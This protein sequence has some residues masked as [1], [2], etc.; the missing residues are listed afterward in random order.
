MDSDCL[1]SASDRKITFGVCFRLGSVVIS[2]A[3]GK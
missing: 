3:S 2:W 1:G